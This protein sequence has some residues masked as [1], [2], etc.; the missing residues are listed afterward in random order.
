MPFSLQQ[1][2]MDCEDMTC[3]L[4]QDVKAFLGTV[5]MKNPLAKMMVFSDIPIL[6]PIAA[7]T[8]YGVN[9]SHLEK[10]VG[11]IIMN[12]AKDVGA[13]T[14]YVNQ[15]LRLNQDLRRQADPKYYSHRDG[16]HMNRAGNR[17]VGESIATIINMMGYGELP[18]AVPEEETK[19]FIV[20]AED[21]EILLHGRSNSCR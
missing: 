11:P 19:H 8:M 14:L 17:F 4:A 2:S 9:A 13:F 18:A 3:P 7:A 10:N 20:T 6:N 5:K 1:N 12:A 15:W 16:F 21:A